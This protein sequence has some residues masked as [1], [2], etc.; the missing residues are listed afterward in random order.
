MEP[1]KRRVTGH[2]EGPHGVEHV[3]RLAVA[4]ANP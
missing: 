3:P 4:P 1:R 2:G